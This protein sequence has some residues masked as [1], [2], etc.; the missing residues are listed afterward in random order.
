MAKKPTKVQVKLQHPQHYALFSLM[1][2]RYFLQLEDGFTV[3]HFGLLDSKNVLLDYFHCILPDHSLDAQKENLVQ[4][5]EQ[6][7]LAKKKIPAWTPPAS[8]ETTGT[9]Q[10]TVPVVDFIHLTH[11]EDAHAEICFWNY[12]RANLADMTVGQKEVTV[13]T[14]GVALIR[15]KID[16]QRSFLAALYDTENASGKSND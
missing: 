5:S 12:S 3:A 16:L 8:S 6:V 13:P 2:N 4:Y 15:C 1:A 10:L 14:W 11:W 9:N 7:G